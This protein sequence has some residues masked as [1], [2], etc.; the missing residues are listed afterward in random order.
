[1]DVTPVA[2][3][4][5]GP[6][7][8]SPAPNPRVAPED[9]IIT[10]DLAEA[11]PFEDAGPATSSSG[12][13][14]NA[15][16]TGLAKALL[17]AAPIQRCAAPGGPTGFGHVVVV[18]DSSGRVVSATLDPPFAGTA[19]GACITRVYSTATVPP[20]IGATAS[21]SKFFTLK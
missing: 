10:V 12:P 4:T 19:V 11:V 16:D 13:P 3:I 21:V 17:M 8:E 15:F 20:F 6:L 7:A 5:S 9:R 2:P 1:M 14:V 18:W